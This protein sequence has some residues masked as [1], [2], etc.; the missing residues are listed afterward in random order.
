MHLACMIGFTDIVKL[1]L[2]HSSI[3]VQLKDSKGR[4]PLTLAKQNGHFNVVKQFDKG[5]TCI[6]L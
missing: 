5:T 1:F 4:T 6:I 3:D 2:L